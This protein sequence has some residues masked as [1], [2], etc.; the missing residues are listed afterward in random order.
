MCWLGATG[1]AEAL[2]SPCP[3]HPPPGRGGFS[4]SSWEPGAD[5]AGQPAAIFVCLP[6]AT[7]PRDQD[8]IQSSQETHPD[9]Y[10]GNPLLP[11]LQLSSFLGQLELMWESGTPGQLINRIE[12]KPFIVHLTYIFISS[13]YQLLSTHFLVGAFVLFTP[14]LPAFLRLC[15][16]LHSSCFTVLCYLLLAVLAFSFSASSSLL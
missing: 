11:K 16:W 13:F 3:C 7:V 5:K 14:F 9:R 15:D 2:L 10:L 8:H 12:Q 6:P 4:W 1:G